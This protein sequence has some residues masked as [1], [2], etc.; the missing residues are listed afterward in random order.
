M[1]ATEDRMREAFNAKHADGRSLMQIA[2]AVADEM[3]AE[4]ISERDAARK[5]LTS[6]ANSVEGSWEA[7]EVA[8][9]EAIGNT[10]YAVVQEKINR[11][12]VTLAAKG[13]E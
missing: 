3:V 1:S 8:L 6:L 2:A 13:S 9:R 11:A 4:A 12:R 7:F 5:A 10:N